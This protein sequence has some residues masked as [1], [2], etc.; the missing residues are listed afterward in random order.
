MVFAP[1]YCEGMHF[2]FVS[3]PEEILAFYRQISEKY[4]IPFWDYSQ[5]SM[6]LR[7]G[8]FY[9]SE[10]MNKPGA[11]LFTKRIVRR[12]GEMKHQ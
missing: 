10:H 9:N 8:Y 4:A 6:C 12:I 5:D 11:D 3:N 2:D 1:F 7:K